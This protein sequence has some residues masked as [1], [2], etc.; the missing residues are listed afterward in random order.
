MSFETAVFVALSVS[1]IVGV[2]SAWVALP[3]VTAKRRPPPG[4]APADPS[5]SPEAARGRGQVTVASGLTLA[6]A[7]DLLDRLQDRGCTPSEVV[8]ADGRVTVR[9]LCPPGRRL[10]RGEGVSAENGT[11]PR[12]RRSRRRSS[13]SGPAPSGR[14][15]SAS[16]SSRPCHAG[17]P[18][19]RFAASSGDSRSRHRRVPLRPV[20]AR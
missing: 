19:V 11:P 10:V 14:A 12:A 1:L 7:E 6:E 17:Y 8:L 20:Q 3:R 5:A 4:P 13:W 2:G 16:R 18:G 9:W 15:G